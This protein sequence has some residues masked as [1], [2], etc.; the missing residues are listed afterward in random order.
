MNESLQGIIIFVA[1][2]II[3]AVI[4]HIFVKRISIAII[5]AAITASATFQAYNY[6]LLGYLGPFF[7]IALVTTTAIAFIIALIVGVPFRIWRGKQHNKAL[8]PTAK[9]GAPLIKDVKL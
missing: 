5:G 7:I 1:I 4:W 2:A 8:H 6:I 3:S 9:S